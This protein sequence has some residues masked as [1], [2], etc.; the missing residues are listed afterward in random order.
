MKEKHMKYFAVVCAL[1]VLVSAVSFGQT[2]KKGDFVASVNSEAWTLSEGKGER[3]HKY[4][5][6][7]D[8]AYANVPTVAVMLNGF[9]ASSDDTD[10]TKKNAT[11]RLALVSEQ[12]TKAGF[13]IKIK[14]WGE[15]KLNAVWGSWIAYGK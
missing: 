8:K 2:M 7:F 1:L 15:S 4:V 5:V 13:V 3:I 12:I 10:G 14:T 6:N 9:D 11:L